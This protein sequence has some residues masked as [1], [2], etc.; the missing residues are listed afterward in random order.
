[1]SALP[2]A[3]PKQWRTPKELVEIGFERSRVVMMNEAHNMLLRSV[4]T[5]EV[6]RHILPA[7]HAAGVR[8]LAMEAL[9]GEIASH[10]N[11]TRTLPAVEGGYLS[12]PE[13]RALI[14]AALELGWSLIPYEVT[15]IRRE[16]DGLDATN[17]RDEH[18]ARNLVDALAS[19]ADDEPLLVWCGNGHLTKRAVGAWRP[20]GFR[21]AELAGVQ[22]FAIDQTRSVEFTSGAPE[23]A[24]WVVNYA[25]VMVRLGGA[26]GFLAEEAPDGWFGA[27]TSDAFVI[28][29]DNR[30]S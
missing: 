19:M 13:M 11:A 9:F 10:A 18:Q 30:M 4:R 15:S 26:A 16:L 8:H 7:A 17:W 28:A 14:E 24:P 2:P 23:A 25:D 6:G 3:P 27:E 5:R 21:F 22:P 12:Q 29:M 20:M 1:V